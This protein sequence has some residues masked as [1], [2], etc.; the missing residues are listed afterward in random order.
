MLKHTFLAAIAAFMLSFGSVYAADEI[1]LNS[2]TNQELQM[3]DGIGPATA[4]AII[5]YREANGGFESMD[6]VQNVNGI[7]EKKA[8]QLSE[9]ATISE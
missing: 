6:E 7:G 1:D 9:H 3:L 5:E 4:E 8:A 2:A